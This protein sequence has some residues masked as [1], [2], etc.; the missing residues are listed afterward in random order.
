M[1]KPNSGFQRSSLPLRPP[2]HKMLPVHYLYSPRAS[3]LTGKLL[4]TVIC[5][6]N[7]MAVCVAQGSALPHH[8][9]YEAKIHQIT[10]AELRAQDKKDEEGL[11]LLATALQVCSY[12]VFRRGAL[13]LSD[14]L[15]NVGSPFTLLELWLHRDMSLIGFGTFDQL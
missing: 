13:Q 6:T 8:M 15:M 4:I 9:W 7:Y 12:I 1:L 11:M 5:K 14:R 2:T 10:T 3:N